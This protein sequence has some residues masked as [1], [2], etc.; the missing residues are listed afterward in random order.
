M[1]L[2][3]YKSQ[4]HPEAEF[5]GRVEDICCLLQDWAMENGHGRRDNGGEFLI[6]GPDDESLRYQLWDDTCKDNL[7]LV[8]TGEL[9][10]DVLK[11]KT[12]T[13]E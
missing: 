13:P 8:L 9:D 2:A 11:I 6:D 10:G 7:T 1:T 4:G 5:E 3:E 12:I